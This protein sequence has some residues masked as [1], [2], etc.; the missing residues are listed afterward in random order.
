MVKKKITIE[1]T[2]VSAV[3]ATA[4]PEITDDNVAEVK[5]APAKTKRK[6]TRKSKT[7]EVLADE[8]DAVADDG[9]I[10]ALTDIAP[11]LSGEAVAV[12]TVEAELDASEV[13]KSFIDDVSAVE[14]VLPDKIKADA[15]A[16]LKAKK[17]NQAKKYHI[18]NPVWCYPSSV[19]PKSVTTICG[20]VYLWDD[21]KVTGRYAVTHNPDGAGKLKALSG[22]VDAKD[23]GL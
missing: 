9:K 21:T 23:L 11:E 20:D 5:E 18:E 10:T 2:P 7:I 8:V 6:S 14:D 12:D 16:K 3:E 15:P 17:P 19:A 22:W 13:A 4:L 1:E